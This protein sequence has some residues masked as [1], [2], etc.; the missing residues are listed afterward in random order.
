MI[1]LDMDQG[2]AAW[3]MARLGI[4]TSS[5]FDE[6]LTPTTL[7]FSK[8]AEKYAWQLIAE[9]AT[10]VPVDDATSGFLTRGTVQE[11]KAVQWYEMRRDVETEG[12]GF[13]LRDDKRAGC[14]PDRFVGTDGLLEVKVPKVTNHIGYLL[15]DE[16]IGY[17][18]QRQGQLW[19]T[20]RE[21][22][23]GLSYC[24]GLPNALTRTYRDE[25]FIKAL[26]AAIAQFLSMLDEM[27]L[28]LQKKG[29]FTDVRIPDLRVVA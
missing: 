25:A 26:D 20:E 12:V 4:P 27:K 15:D 21:W 6:I 14:S 18:C 22:C 9:Q 1:R 11:K 16:G 3:L 10:G 8:S 5:R 28:K 13:I 2:S 24:P 29:L 17:R 7:K 23:D 19:L